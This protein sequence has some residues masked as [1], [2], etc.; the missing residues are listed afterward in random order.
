MIEECLR[1][2]WTDAKAV[3]GVSEALALLGFESA[4]TF[5]IRNNPS[6]VVALFLNGKAFV[7]S[8]Y[9]EEGPPLPILITFESAYS[10]GQSL[11]DRYRYV[12]ISDLL[13]EL[14]WL[15]QKHFEDR[16]ARRPGANIVSLGLPDI[17][18]RWEAS[19]AA[20]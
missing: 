20:R 16:I 7:F 12:S 13:S 18:R 15:L 1:P 4:G 9:R 2:G 19:L 5:W 11:M 17:R 6:S 14:P 3:A 10:D 8:Q